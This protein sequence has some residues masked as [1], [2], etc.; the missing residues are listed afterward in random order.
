MHGEDSPMGPPGPNDIPQYIEDNNGSGQYFQREQ[1]SRWAGD[2]PRPTFVFGIIAP[3]DGPIPRFNCFG[4]VENYPGDNP[5]IRTE[6]R[7]TPYR[8]GTNPPSPE[9]EESRH[10]EVPQE[11]SYATARLFRGNDLWTS[12]TGTTQSWA[13]VQRRSGRL[14]TEQDCVGAS[15]AP[16][17]ARGTY[18]GSRSSAHTGQSRPCG[19]TAWTRRAPQSEWVIRQA[20]LTTVEPDDCPPSNP[21]YPEVEE[22]R[23]AR[24][25]ERPLAAGNIS[26]MY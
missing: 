17:G 11:D 1:R 4:V 16:N 22:E 25:R 26:V 24:M 20:D 18:Q 8:P 5:G 15:P 7:G 6:N 12:L 3:M 19:C 13:R 21:R 9:R 14:H 10:L 2:L 23:I